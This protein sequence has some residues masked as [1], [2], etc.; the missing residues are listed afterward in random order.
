MYIIIDYSFVNFI[1]VSRPIIA[2]LTDVFIITGQA[3][4]YL[5]DNSGP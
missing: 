3:I 2:V 4:I 1:I 5:L